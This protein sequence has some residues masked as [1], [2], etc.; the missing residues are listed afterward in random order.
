M[1]DLKLEAERCIVC[2]N[3]RC[4][5]NCP[6]NTEIPKIINLYKEGKLL[7][8]G[9]VLF[10]NNP[11][12]AVCS[13]VCPHEDQCA[14]NCIR[15]IKGEPI[16]FYKIEEEIS[17]AYLEHLKF[18][19]APD[20]G[21]RIAIV[22]SGP[23]GL[24]VAFEL[25]KKGYAV[26]VFEKND[27]L[28]GILRYG[29]PEFRLPRTIIDNLVKGLKSLGVKFKIN[30]LVGPIITIDKLFEDRYDAI[31]I[32]TGVWNPRKLEIKGE[33]L[34]H[35]HYAIDYLRSPKNYDLGDKVVVIGAGN[36]AMDASRSAKYYGSKDVFVAYR[37]DI[38]DMTATK[39]EIHEAMSEGVEFMTFKAP[40]EVVDEGIILCDTKKVIDE[41]GKISLVNVEDSEHLFK[42]DSVLVAVS[43]IPRNTI[44]SNNKGL[45]VNN[46]GLLLTDDSGHTTRDG[47][48]ACGDVTHGAST[49]IE[50]V[51]AAK[52][53]AQSIVE[54]TS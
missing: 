38:E 4:Q 35:V 2:N 49:V 37:R 22:G 24:T 12:S 3:A 43:Q 18:D 15:G 29:I 1:I 8:A 31:F 13:I 36:V 53:V 17:T 26:T 42:C 33:S 52:K 25:A 50:A 14:G 44:V 45:D 48:F 27:Q 5:K 54:F 46:R 51:V 7:E 20:N 23:A 41:N 11:L 39:F 9:E 34:G 40:V 19:K 28:G 32:G 30:S 10:N 47:V 21:K 6:I 16:Q